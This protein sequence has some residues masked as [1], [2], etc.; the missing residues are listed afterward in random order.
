MKGARSRSLFGGPS[1]PPPTRATR[2]SRA[3]ALG[4]GVSG[5]RR[6]LNRIRRLFFTP[7]RVAP[8]H[9]PSA[10]ARRAPDTPRLRAA[11]A[12]LLLAI[13]AAVASAQS[14]S[15]S[16]FYETVTFAP[17]AVP[18]PAPTTALP[19][20]APTFCVDTNG[21]ALSGSDFFTPGRSWQRSYEDPQQPRVCFAFTSSRISFVS[22]C[23]VSLLLFSS[24]SRFEKRYMFDIA[25]WHQTFITE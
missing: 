25:K 15:Y 3:R 21:G 6:C 2:L 7:L 11:F 1:L 22:W 23:S 9:P 10:L 18:V 13:N 5:S 14:Y 8:A 4:L 19:T 24:T 17:T 20:P 12:T 16:Y